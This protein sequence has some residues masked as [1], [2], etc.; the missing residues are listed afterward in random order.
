MILSFNSEWLW[1]LECKDRCSIANE[2]TSETTD[3][4]MDHNK[5]SSNSN[6]SSNNSNV[7]LLITSTS[8]HI[9]S[10]HITSVTS[11]LT[12]HPCLRVSSASQIA[13]PLHLPAS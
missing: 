10:H 4:A 9:T 7:S 5:G 6:N 1:Y 13:P 8:H 3:A 2:Q 12:S 11:H